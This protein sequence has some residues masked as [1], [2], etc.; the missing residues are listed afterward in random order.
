MRGIIDMCFISCLIIRRSEIGGPQEMK[1]NDETIKSEIGTEAAWRG[2]STQTLYIAK[3]LLE[4]ENN[5]QL[6]PEH[7]EDLMIMENKKVIE[8]VQVKNLSTDLSLSDLSPKKNDSF[9]RRC[10]AYKDNKICLRIVSFGNIGL[11]FRKMLQKKNKKSSSVFDKLLSYG[12]EEN[13]V[14]WLLEHLEIE[15]VDELEIENSIKDELKKYLEVVA[16][17]N[18]VN[19]SLIYYIYKLS[20][21]KGYTSKKLWEERI[22]DIAK[23]IMAI[24][25][26]KKQYQKTIIPL[27]DYKSNKTREELFS[28]YR[29]GV[30]AH[31]DHI[32]NNCDLWRERWIKEIDR[33]FIKNNIVLIKGASGQ[34]KSTLAY[35]YLIDT[36]PELN[37]MC[38]QKLLSE[39]QAIDILS[40]LRGLNDRKDIVIYM[41][42]E[43]YDTQWLWLCEKALEFGI[44]IKI[45]VS[46][47]EEDFQRSPIDYSK[48]NFEEIS[49]DFSK[50]EAKEIYVMYSNSTYLSFYDAW[51]SFGEKGPLMEYIFMLNESK[52]LVA[53]INAQIENIIN[54]EEQADAWLECLAIISLGGIHNNNISINSLFQKVECKQKF[55]MIKHFEKEYFIKIAQNN[56]YIECLHVL[57]ARIIY[58]LLMERGIFDKEN[59]LIKTLGVIEH[60][61]TQMLIEYVYELGITEDFVNRIANIKYL[62]IEVYAD[63]VKA[64]LWCEIDY[65]YQVN[66]KVIEEGDFLFN[67]QFMFPGNTD[68]TG[69][70]EIDTLQ[71][72][73]K[74]FNDLKP[75]FEKQMRVQLDKLPMLKLD[76]RFLDCFF[77]ITNKTIENLYEIK[78]ENLTAWGYILFWMSY[79]NFILE[80]ISE[81]DID[82]KL[83]IEE[84]LNYVLGIGKQ[85]WFNMRDSIVEVIMPSILLENGVIYYEIKNNEVFVIINV[86]PGNDQEQ[87]HS[88]IMKLISIFQRSFPEKKKYNVKIVGYSFLEEVEIPD[89]EKNISQE[90]LPYVWI[91]QL[92]KCFRNMQKYHNLPRNWKDT[93]ERI[94][95]ARNAILDYF[96]ILLDAVEKLYRNENVR[97]FSSDNYKKKKG[98]AYNLTKENPYIEPMCAVD[99]YGIRDDNYVVED[100]HQKYSIAWNQESDKEHISYLCHQYF[101]HVHAFCENCENVLVDAKTKTQQGQ[102]SGI[103]YY[104]LIQALMKLHAFQEKFDDYFSSFGVFSNNKRELDI[105]EKTAAVFTIAFFNNYAREKSICYR[106]KESMRSTERKIVQFM[107]SGVKILPGVTKVIGEINQPVIDVEIFQYEKFLLQFYNSLKKLG[108]D[109]DNTS[110]SGYL[111]KKHFSTLHVNPICDGENTFPGIDIPARDFL[112]YKEFNKFLRTVLP[113]EE[114][115]TWEIINS[116]QAAIQGI[117]AISSLKI[118]FVYTSEIEHEL[119][120]KQENTIVK[121]VFCQYQRKVIDLICDAANIFKSAVEYI[122]ANT[123]INV[124]EINDVKMALEEIAD[125]LCEDV[126]AVGKESSNKYVADFFEELT[127]RFCE[128]VDASGVVIV[129]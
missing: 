79:R 85:G 118:L 41:D 103:A 105:L 76:Y 40:I 96:I 38:I 107:E 4:A 95:N 59:I 71:D 8:L 98:T 88:R 52:T 70:L 37:V 58:N 81:P 65:Y 108:K 67:N 45:L 80:Q 53:R 119:L 94:I 89:T 97:I 69:L 61:A 60:N 28:A 24:D 68:I 109:M 11:E 3:R 54:H 20:R 129:N 36:Y 100:N 35:R 93:Y 125:Q 1:N 74:I 104:N 87:P 16:A 117:G 27:C 7:V 115:D 46:I 14:L 78:E 25:S 106:A 86:L 124:S 43:P 75:D 126:F 84:T 57:R 50:D 26:V 49:L 72:I 44:D 121:D 47:R 17:Y 120:D 34:G 114:K 12:Y 6:Y 63:I 18:L 116:S 39:E 123:V 13:D 64:L 122:C 5:V 48:H 31:P 30:N 56:T 113:N 33:R 2:F 82:W 91:T 111:L 112:I 22:N 19:D 90:H 110:F 73:C 55:K 29:M 42:V 66:K 101:S 102:E 62:S 51:K 21:E 127:T 32:R 9:F 83:N 23:N 15:K 128:Y 10:L 92:N 77:E 99:R